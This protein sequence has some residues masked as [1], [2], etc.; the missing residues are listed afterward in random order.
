MKGNKGEWSELYVLFKLLSD[1]SLYSGDEN[2]NKITDVVYPIVNI[3]RIEKNTRYEYFFDQN[4]VIIFEDGIDKIKIEIE[5]FKKNALFLLNAIKNAK[6]SSFEINELEYFISKIKVNTLKAKS[7]DKTDI[8]IRVHDQQTNQEPLLG[9]SIKSQ[10]GSASTLFNSNKDTTNF[11]YEVVGELTDDE[12]EDINSINSRSK[13]RDR[14]DSIKVKGLG[15]KFKGLNNSMF[16]NNLTL[17]D[18]SL[19]AILA[20]SILIFFC[21]N[22]KTLKEIVANLHELNPLNFDISTGHKYYEYKIKKLLSDIAL[23]M[24]PAK[25]WDGIYSSTGGYLVVKENGDVICYHIYNKNQFESYLFNNTKFETPST[26]RHNFGSIYKENGI[27]Y[28]NLNLQ[29]RFVK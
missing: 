12:I 27:N 11:Q 4:F 15:I 5:E 1:K 9:F 2:L 3:L 22:K 24:M 29:I 23:G 7:S 26:S 10:F 17:I 13:V 19:P 20:D 14:I 18:T 28:F 6:G 21:T 8:L 25:K 16:S